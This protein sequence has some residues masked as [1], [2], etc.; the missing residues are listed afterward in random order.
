MSYLIVGDSSTDINEEIA[1]RGLIRHVPLTM[2]LDGERIVDDETFDQKAFLEKVASSSDYPK[3]SCP[4]PGDFMQHY[5]EADEIYVITL[6]GNLSGS[7]NS[8]EVAKNLYLEDH[9]DAKIHVFDSCSASVGQTLVALK[10]ME[11]KDAGADFDTVVSKVTKYRDMKQTRFILDTLETF[12]KNGRI[13]NISALLISTLNIKPIMKGTVDGKIE[14]LDQARGFNKSLKLLS[15]HIGKEMK[16]AAASSDPD[17]HPENRILAI[18]HCNNPARAQ[19][20]LDFISQQV[21]FKEVVVVNMRGLSST[22]ANDGGIIVS[23]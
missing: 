3:S 14:K 5:G 11:L 21:K 15:E 7:Y 10:I 12:R 16:A 19:I 9:P 8:A 18:S 20:A 4:S 6:S 2:E 22:Y 1:K 23:Y 17:M 13:N